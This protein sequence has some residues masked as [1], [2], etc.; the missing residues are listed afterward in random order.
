MPAD[1]LAP[2]GRFKG[3]IFMQKTENRELG[4]RSALVIRLADSI[5]VFGIIYN[6][7]FIGN[8]NGFFDVFSYVGQCSGINGANDYGY[9]K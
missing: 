4:S 8:A 5:S 9:H 6:N 1:Q 2:V 3:N 7:D